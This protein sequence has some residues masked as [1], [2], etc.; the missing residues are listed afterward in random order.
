MAKATLEIQQVTLEIRQMTSEIQPMRLEISQVTLE[1]YMP[2]T[3]PLT[4]AHSGAPHPLDHQTGHRSYGQDHACN[5]SYGV[6]VRIETLL[7]KTEVL[8]H[9]L[10][11]SVDVVDSNHFGLDCLQRG[12]KLIRVHDVWYDCMLLVEERRPDLAKKYIAV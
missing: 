3:V 2:L 5:A 11:R 1:T 7:R 10:Q 6:G 12:A 8:D 4:T 9:S